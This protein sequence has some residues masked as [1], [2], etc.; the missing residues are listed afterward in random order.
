MCLWQINC[1]ELF[2]A[3]HYSTY[4]Y[5]LNSDATSLGKKEVSEFF[6][7]IFSLIPMLI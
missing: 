4:V 3:L 1:G 5:V 7:S 6:F 2:I